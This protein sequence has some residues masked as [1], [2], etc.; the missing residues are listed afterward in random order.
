MTVTKTKLA[1][2]DQCNPKVALGWGALRETM[3]V[4]HFV[5]GQLHDGKLLDMDSNE[6]MNPGETTADFLARMAKKYL[7]T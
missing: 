2:C 5:N 4:K 1:Y 3:P 6:P 7:K